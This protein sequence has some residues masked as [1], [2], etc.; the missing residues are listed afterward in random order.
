MFSYM[1]LNPVCPKLISNTQ[2]F[3]KI[4]VRNEILLYVGVPIEILFW[5]PF[6]WVPTMFVFM[7]K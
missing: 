2:V 5:R 4:N 7:G 3:W 1:Y 6:Q